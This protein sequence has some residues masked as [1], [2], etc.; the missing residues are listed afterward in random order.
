MRNTE[1]SPFLETDDHLNVGLTQKLKAFFEGI[2]A[3][4][5]A[6]LFG[7]AATG[8]SRKDS[9]VDI[10]AVFEDLLDTDSINDLR[11]KLN[12]LLRR[13]VD[14]VSLNRA[15]PILKMQVL[16]HGRLIYASDKKHL[17]QFFVD[18]VNQYHDL[19]TIRKRCEESILKGRLYA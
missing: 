16:K 18:T 2:P 10:G 19:K 9:D 8:H 1:E 6:Y 3:V 7:S 13:E 12:A 11:D 17:H 15:S 4:A 5:L 14:L